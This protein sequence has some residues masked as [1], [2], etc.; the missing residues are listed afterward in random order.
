MSS[1]SISAGKRFMIRFIVA[2]FLGGASLSMAVGLLASSAWLISMASTQPPVLTLQVAVVSVRFFGLSRGIFRYAERIYGHDAI[3]RAASALQ[4]SLYAALIHRE[5]VSTSA[6][7]QGKLLQQLTSDIELVQDRWVRLFIPGL[8]AAVSAWAGFGIV[9]WL[10]PNISLLFIF[11]YLA[12]V[13]ATFFFS[14]SLTRRHSA[15]VFEAESE[16]A[17]LVSDTIRGHLEARMYGYEN[18][19][20]LDLYQ[21]EKRIIEC[22][23]KMINNAGISNAL[24]LLGLYSMLI[25]GFINAS[26]SFFAG[27]L[28]GVNIAVITLLPL[29]IFDGIGA[30]IAPLSQFG[31]IRRA[32]SNIDSIIVSEEK[33]DGTASLES[34]SAMIKSVAARAMWSGKPVIHMPLTFTLRG[35]EILL[36]QGESGIGKSS[37]AL[38]LSGLIPYQGS[39]R[40]NGIEVRDIKRSDLVSAITL[41]S[42]DDHLFNT[43]IRENLKIANPDADDVTI[44]SILDAVEL[45]DLIKS[46]PDGLDTHIGAFGKNFSGGELQRMRLARALLR[47]S[48]IYVLDEPLEHLESVQALRIFENIRQ[49]LSGSTIIVISHEEIPDVTNSVSLKPDFNQAIRAN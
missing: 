34:G 8:S 18:K 44:M 11:I 47:H 24:L 3:L 1:I 45:S 30:L 38:A 35:G 19:I 49:Q 33:V 12:T 46:L 4:L 32:T 31:K 48:P 22:E 13:T 20:G 26:Q 43:S 42:Q 5:P 28:S 2:G 37:F 40:I 9:H 14:G 21:S 23:K 27:E 15:E 41:S 25:L 6:M 16:I 7:G 29:A 17:E 10:A 36:L 39:I